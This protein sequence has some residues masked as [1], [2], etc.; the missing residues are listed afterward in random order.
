[1]TVDGRD[2]SGIRLTAIPLIT[3]K[4]RLRLVTSADDALPPATGFQVFPRPVPDGSGIRPGLPGPNGSIRDDY[5]FELRTN[6]ER[7]FIDVFSAS[8]TSRRWTTK[9]VHVSGRDVT[10]TGI[11]LRPGEDIEGIEVE[12]STQAATVSG[13]VTDA[14]DKPSTDFV[15]I[16]FPQNRDLWITRPSGRFGT[17]R[18]DQSGRFE[19]GSLRTGDYYAAAV[20]Y[21]EP[22]RTTSV[23][24]LERL[25]AH[26]QKISLTDGEAK[27]MELK[28][29]EP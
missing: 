20:E 12:L 26:A 3:I 22:G 16:L 14:Q 17:G 18:P 4:G 25:A 1:V 10:D 27:A 19:M 28:L 24:F 23:D 6:P 7:V 29:V 8:P 2:I 5:T 21:V 9:S 13:T 15:V 11:E